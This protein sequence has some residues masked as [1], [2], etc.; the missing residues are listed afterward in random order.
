MSGKIFN[1]A[2]PAK[3]QTLMPIEKLLKI[4]QCSF[5]DHRFLQFGS[6]TLEATLTLLKCFKF[7]MRANPL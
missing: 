4:F 3:S 6:F 5:E 7:L 1:V 2:K